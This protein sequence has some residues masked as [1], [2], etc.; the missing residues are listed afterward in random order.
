MSIDGLL[1]YSGVL[2]VCSSMVKGNKCY[3]KSVIGPGV[4]NQVNR[5]WSRSDAKDVSI[6]S[7]SYF[8]ALSSSG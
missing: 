2:L 7:V 6:G 5:L 8:H 3:K 1:M 4:G